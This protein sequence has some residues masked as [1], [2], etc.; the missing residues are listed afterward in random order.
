MLEPHPTA[1]TSLLED[2][3]VKL[4]LYDV[5]HVFVEHISKFTGTFF[6][7]HSRKL[8]ILGAVEWFPCHFL[9]RGYLPGKELVTWQMS[10]KERLYVPVNY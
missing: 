10:W 1:Y 5:E 2:R 6:K 4:L 8:P 9:V 3:S 7:E